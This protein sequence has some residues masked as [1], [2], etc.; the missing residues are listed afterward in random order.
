MPI[1]GALGFTFFGTWEFRETGALI[2]AT[3]GEKLRFCLL[4][5]ALFCTQQFM[6]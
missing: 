5:L 1:E 3:V 4:N 6:N 2:S